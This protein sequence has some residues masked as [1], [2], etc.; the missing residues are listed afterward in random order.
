MK[1]K[2]IE[3]FSVFVDAKSDTYRIWTVLDNVLC[4]DFAE[5][6]KTWAL[7]F[8]D[9]KMFCFSASLLGAYTRRPCLKIIRIP[10]KVHSLTFPFV[11][12]LVQNVYPWCP[13]CGGI[14][15]VNLLKISF[16]YE[17]STSKILGLTEANFLQM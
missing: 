1:V 4:N 7:W 14:P 13:F 3:L 8:M 12:A 5:T 10:R 9:T 17:I 15:I 2:K 16:Y 11:T 6:A